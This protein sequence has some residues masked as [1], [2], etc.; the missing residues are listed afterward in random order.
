MRSSPYHRLGELAG[1]PKPVVQPISLNGQ[2]LV[3]FDRNDWRVGWNHV[4]EFGWY[5]LTNRVYTLKERIVRNNAGCPLWDP[6]TWRPVLEKYRELSQSPSF[7][8]KA[9]ETEV[10]ALEKRHSQPTRK[11]SPF[12]ACSPLHNVFNHLL[13]YI[14]LEHHPGLVVLPISRSAGG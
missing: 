14:L 12:E 6:V 2:L 9:T 1:K 10:A 13:V 5:L 11:K 4:E 8:R 3:L 7:D